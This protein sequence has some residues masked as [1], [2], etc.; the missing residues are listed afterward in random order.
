MCL[1][2][3][4]RLPV[5]L[6][7]GSPPEDKVDHSK[8]NYVFRLKEKLN[9]IHNEARQRMKLKSLKTKAIYDRKA[10]QIHYEPGQRVWLFNPRK[11]LGRTPKLQSNW[12]GS[13]EIVKKLNDVVYC[14]RKSKKHKNKIVHLDRLAS[15]HE[16]KI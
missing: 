14:I 13:Y 9:E 10:R 8:E 2:R 7:Q 16:R 1:G 5:D 4:L 6:L 12:E 3:D 15:Y 11:V